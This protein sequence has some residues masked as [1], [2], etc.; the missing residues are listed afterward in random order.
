MT[1][2][3]LLT[4]RAPEKRL[5]FGWQRAVGRNAQGKITVRHRGGGVKRRY[6]AIDFR[7]DKHD[8]PAVVETIEYDPNRTTRIA[9]VRYADGERR[10]V[11]APEGL[12]PGS[13][14]VVSQSAPIVVGN[15]LPLAAIPVGTPVFNIEL[16][17]GGGA[18][19]VRSAGAGAELAAIEGAY[20]HLKLPSG[21]I[22]MVLAGS[23]ATIGSASNP[24]W[25]FM[26]VGSAGRNRRRGIRPTV[27]GSAMNPREHPYGGSPGR[28][29]RGTRRP[30]TMWGKIVGGVK[31]RKR[32]R[33]DRF[34]LQRR[35]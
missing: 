28:A 35:K 24:E 1:S 12:R 2:P 14:F 34:I 7:Y 30:K 18:K 20:A 33:S 25:M 26:T 27:R 15:R 19:L 23:W 10:Y 4:D 16:A 11:L 21:E 17:P 5:V 29:S 32:K 22:R 31:T 3:G 8:I 13:R 6:R 9:L